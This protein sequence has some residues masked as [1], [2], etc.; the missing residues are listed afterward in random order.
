MRDLK[1]VQVAVVAPSYVEFDILMRVERG[2]LGGR[3]VA[4]GRNF[5][6][7]SG[8]TIRWMPIG[9]GLRARLEA[10]LDRCRR[11]TSCR[12]RHPNEG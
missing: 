2:D 5:L 1:S 8:V 6:R 3:T 4:S 10:R 12:L 9:A 11:S 7:V